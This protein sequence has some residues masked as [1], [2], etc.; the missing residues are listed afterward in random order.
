M[1]TA[2]SSYCQLCNRATRR[3]R[4]YMNRGV[5]L[6]AWLGSLQLSPVRDPLSVPLETEFPSHDITGVLLNFIE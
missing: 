4:T 1:N 6:E 2:Q 5:M 3:P